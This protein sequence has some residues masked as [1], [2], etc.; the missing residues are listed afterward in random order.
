MSR[1][2]AVRATAF[3][4]SV[5]GLAAVTTD[6]VGEMQQRHH[7]W[8]VVSAALGRTASFGAMMG[9]MLKNESDRLTIQ[10]Q[11]DGPIGEILV[12]AD[13]RGGVRGT[14][15]HPVVD[16]PLNDLGKLDVAR[17]VGAGTLNVVKDLGMREPYRGSVRLVSGELGDDF[18]Y[19][20]T[21][22]EQV[23]SSVGVGVLVDRDA[24][25]LASGGFIIQVMPGTG[26]ERIEEL[27][28]RV[29]R[30]PSVTQQLKR[31]ATPEDLLERV[32]GDGEPQVLATQPLSFQCQCSEERTRTMLRS[33]GREELN[34]IIREQG[35]AEVICHFC[36]QTYEISREELERLAEEAKS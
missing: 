9:M 29:R 32:L 35:R 17:A 23:P 21:V 6:L 33:L 8:P 28:E 13:A 24:S 36:N 4:G 34:S 7:T 2:Y 22:S 14:V 26:D 20:L 25:I 12:D 31:G 10:V 15:T 16:L 3:G 27:E 18:T 5:L 1:D 11:G 19:Y 30:V